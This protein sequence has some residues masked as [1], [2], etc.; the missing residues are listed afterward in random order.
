MDNYI[1][2]GKLTPNKINKRNYFAFNQVKGLMHIPEVPKNRGYYE[3]INNMLQQVARMNE[4]GKDWWFWLNKLTIIGSVPVQF[5]NILA[6]VI[7][8]DK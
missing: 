5:N 7:F 3:D 8:C 4:M 2:S 6:R 1:N